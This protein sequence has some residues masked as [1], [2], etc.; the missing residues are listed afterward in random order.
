MNKEKLAEQML[1]FIET[2]DGDRDVEWYASPRDFASV[3]LGDFAK[4]LG[5]ELVIP[6]YIPRKTAPEVDRQKMFEQLLP[7][8]KDLFDVEY[9]KRTEQS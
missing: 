5:I 9:R 3:V 6:E 4:H 7:H 2:Q 1:E 8:I